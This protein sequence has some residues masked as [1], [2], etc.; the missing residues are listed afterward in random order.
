VQHFDLDT[1]K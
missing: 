1:N